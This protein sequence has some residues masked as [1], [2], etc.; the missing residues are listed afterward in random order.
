[1][2]VKT[3]QIAAVL[4]TKDV[5]MRVPSGLNAT[6][7]N[8]RERLP[9]HRYTLSR[10]GWETPRDLRSRLERFELP[11]WRLIERALNHIAA[12]S[13]FNFIG[14]RQRLFKESYDLPAFLC[15]IQHCT[16]LNR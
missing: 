11:C 4:F 6:D 5:T 16:P 9:D 3:S 13:I 8:S 7:A 15:D 12:M 2:P 14:Q 10:A 1:V